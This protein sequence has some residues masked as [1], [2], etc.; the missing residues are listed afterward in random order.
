MKPAFAVPELLIAAVLAAPLAAWAD[1]VDCEPAEKRKAAALLA[2]A[3]S[4]DKA[5]RAAEA[6]AAAKEEGGACLK[7]AEEQRRQA[8][9]KQT[10]LKLGDE[11]E[12]KSRFID[13]FD[14]YQVG[15]H[16]LEADRA[17][18]RAVRA[19]SGDL[20]TVNRAYAYLRRT[21]DDLGR[22]PQA[23]RAP[24]HAKRAKAGAAYLAELDAL[25]KKNGDAALADEEKVFTTRKVTQGAG[26]HSLDELERSK[27]WLDLIGQSGRANQRA[28]QR[29]DALAAGDARRALQLAISYYE[30]AGK[31]A[32]VQKTKDKAKSIGEARL[33]AGEKLAAAEYF[34]IAGQDSRAEQLREAT[35]AESERREV[36]RKKQFAKEQDDLEKEL[37]LD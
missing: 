15:Q 25:A 22:L 36:S 13:A 27:R 29:G 16:G 34:E 35:E 11:A 23:Q 12:K 8:I 30:F 14:Y 1:E 2:T 6:F 28:E 10:S 3:E 31:S 33:R 26:A 4:A 19:K 18:I 37:G 7:G 5:G 21:H 32:K 9:L 20:E 24:N 17:M